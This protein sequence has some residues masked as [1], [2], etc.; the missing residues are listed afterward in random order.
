MRNRFCVNADA[1]PACPLLIVRSSHP[2]TPVWHPPGLEA[3]TGGD[4]SLIGIY[5]ETGHLP[6]L[7][8]AAVAMPQPRS[9]RRGLRLAC[10]T[11]RIPI[12]IVTALPSAK[13]GKVAHELDRRDPFD[14]F[15]AQ[16]VL[17]TEPERRS[18]QHADGAPFIS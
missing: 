10:D 7:G 12:F 14:H 2:I 15:E 13:V 5:G 18:V 16:F 17:A 11:R 9:G 3:S 8:S 6:E 1:R 4:R